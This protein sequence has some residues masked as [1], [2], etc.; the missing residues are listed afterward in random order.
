MRHPDAGREFL[1]GEGYAQG[2]KRLR[3]DATALCML[4]GR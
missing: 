4:G 1:K 3:A 2:M